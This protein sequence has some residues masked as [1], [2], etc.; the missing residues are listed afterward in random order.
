VLERAVA[1]TDLPDD[2]SEMKKDL[3]L[4]VARD[5]LNLRFQELAKREG[6]P[7]LGASAYSLRDGIR[8]EDGEG[9][10][11]TCTPE[12]WAQALAACEIELRRAVEFGFDDSELAE[13][14]A[15]RLR[16]LDEAVDREKTRASASCVS[17]LVRAAEERQV[18]TAAA[19]DRSILKPLIEALDAKACSEAFAAAWKRGALIVAASGNLD[20]GPDAAKTLRET[21][22][23][24]AKT[25]VERE[26]KEATKPFA[27]ASDA[28]KAGA[29]ASR[30]HVD[31]FD[32]EEI[33][34]QNGVRLH[35]KKTDFKKK[36]ILVSAAIG[37]GN[38]TLEA[39]QQALG[40][41]TAE[42]YEAGGLGAH[43]VDDLRKLDAGKQ[44]GVGFG[45]DTDHFSLS[46]A[47]TKEDLLRELE[48]LTAYLTDPGWREEGLRELK[49]GIPVYF[50]SLEHQHGGPITA[51]FLPEFLS[52]DDRFRFATQ[53]EFEAVT[54]A[55]MREWLAPRL[56]KAPID[57]TIV[58]DVDLDAVVTAAARTFGALPQ[59]RAAKAYEERRKPVHLQTGLKRNYAIETDV[60]KTL[61][62]IVFPA[63]DG[64]DTARRRRMQYLAQV[65]S[66]RLRVEVREKLGASYSPAAGA[67]LGEVYPGDGWLV[68]RAMSEPDK[69]DALVEACFKVTDSMA[70]KG[71]TAE[72][73]E[74]QRKPAQAEVR[75]RVRTNGYWLDALSKLHARE[76]VFDDLRTFAT[77]AD[78]VQ[79]SDLQP[80]AKE[81]LKRENACVAIVAPKKKADSGE[82][83]AA[84]PTPPKKD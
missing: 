30:S 16:S 34:F 12:K 24:S 55:A 2:Q 5:M 52:G 68:V 38:L 22:E 32:L 51:K 45:I 64:R 21:Y 11:I 77:F 35:L 84:E 8:A 62:L 61:V 27:Y 28:S 46:G 54:T 39:K 66:D 36:Q 6:A 71:L 70:E 67:N 40:A 42:V 83:K 9:L 58:G 37:E 29:I 48:L 59:R 76:H 3:P 43:S 25:A 75:D 26:K 72:E 80:L 19:T 13:V 44:L 15:N 60:E 81:Y 69:T 31:E 10:S 17:E 74:R 78:T 56:D 41:A 53:A 65:L 1:W 63:T 33:V 47:T 79:V 18:P 23:T 82:T 49:K 4:R 7:Y 14:R 50:D 57:L 73:V 20:L